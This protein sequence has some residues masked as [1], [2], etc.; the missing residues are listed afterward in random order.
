MSRLA[1]KRTFFMLAAIAVLTMIALTQPAGAQRPEKEVTRLVINPSPEFRTFARLSESQGIEQLRAL[2][3]GA[4]YEEIWAYLPHEQRWVELGCCERQTKRGNYVGV[5][6]HVLRLMAAHPRLV[7]YHIHTPTHFIRENYHQ[8]RRL[9]KEVEE[10]L[11]SATDMATMIKLSREHH[12]LHP[13][14]HMTW[15]I[16]SRHGVTTYGLNSRAMAGYD[17]LDLKPYMF[18]VFDDDELTDPEESTR[19]LI[20]IAIKR[21]AK[22]PFVLKFIPKM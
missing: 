5:D 16:V 19:E 17:E 20:E 10:A 8:N 3:P 15:R 1:A 14:G 7:M 12:K 11:P 21:L 4:D 9:L 18:S 22:T 6:G 13:K 2:I